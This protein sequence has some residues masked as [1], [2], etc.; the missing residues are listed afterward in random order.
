MYISA[1]DLREP[2]LEQDLLAGLRRV[3]PPARPI[4]LL[5]EGSAPRWRYGERLSDVIEESCLRHADRT[6]V[7]VET[8]DISY[9]ELDERANQMA[10]FLMARGVRPGDRVA[11][12]LDRGIETYVA[13]F[14]LLKAG[15][16]YVPLDANHPPDRIRFICS[17]AGANLAV[18]HLRLA[19]RL[20]GCRAPTLVLDG[21]RD[22]IASCDRTRLAE[23]ERGPAGDTLSYVLYTSGTT[24]QPKGVA[25]A[26]RSICN[27]VRVAA[28]RYG[29]GFGDRVY[30]GMSAAF[31]FSI[32]EVWV[33]LAAGA[34][35]VPNTGATSL[36]G[37]EL[38]DF[39]ESRKVTC[40]C[41]VPTLLASIEREL[42]RLRILLIG[43]EACPSAL[44]KRWGRAGRTLLN[45]YGPT[46]AT[47]TATLG[48]MTPDK[49][50]TIGKP[51]PTY[52]IVILDPKEDV[53]LSIGEAGE[54]GIAGV[55]VA[56]G[57]LNRLDLTQA[58]FIED[59]LVLPNN[60]SGRIYRTGDLG[61]I[62]ESGEVEYLGRIDK[63]I[64]LR[65]YR[66]ELTEIESVL[67]EIPEIS[68]VVA[69]TFE[70]APGQAE[71]VAYYSVKHGANAPNRA[72]IVSHMR[73]KLPSYMTPAYLEQL[74][75]IPTQVSNKADRKGLPAPKSAR[76]LLGQTHV[77]PET[78]TESALCRALAEVLGLEEVS[79]DGDFFADYSAH[80]LLMARFCARIR[81]LE[82]SLQVAM[83]DVYAHGTVRRLARALDEARPSPTENLEVP[84]AH[85]PS[86]LAY[87]GCAAAQLAFYAVVGALA[88]AAA[89]AAFVWIYDAADSPLALYGRALGVAT[90][91]FLGHNALAVAAKWALI[92]RARRGSV[93]IWSFAY[94]RF[95]AAKLVV[96]S[97][98]AN[99]FAGTA[100]FNVFLRLLG[101]R[102]GRNALIASRFVPVTADLF[103]VGEDAVVMRSALLPGYCA[104]GNRIHTGA[105]RIGRN[106]YVGEH[107]V[108]EIQTAIGDCGQL[109][110]ASSLQSG[111]RV[112]DGQ[113]H[114]GSP[115]EE[116]TTS[117][118]LADEVSVSP[119]RR[120]LFNAMRLVFV[121]AVAGAL[122]DAVI[123]YAMAV[124]S[125]GDDALAL[126]PLDAAVVVAPMAASA[127]LAVA[128]VAL[129]G[130]LLIVYAVPR[131]AN[132]FLVEGQVYP[133]YGFHHGMQQIVDTF[134]N[135]RFFNLMFGDSVLI[136][137]YLRWVGW[138]LGLGDRTGS[139]FG[140]EQGQDNPFLC[141]VGANTV[142]SDALWLGNVTMSSRAYRLGACRIGARNFLGTMV[143][144]PPGARTGDNV[145]LATKVMAP[146]DGP[147]RENVG[148]L[149][150]P[151]FEIPRAASRDLDVL[152]A[153]GPEERARR[154]VRKTWLNMA[155][156]AGLLASRW[157]ILFIGIYVFGWTVAVY[158]VNDPLP[159]IVS[160]AVIVALSTAV[161]IVIERASLGF[162]RLKPE[163]ATVYDPAFWRIERHWKLSDTPLA[164]AFA[165]T[166]MRNVISRLL[167][168]KVGRRVF[169][170]GCILS[171]R[172]LVEI[173]DEANLNEHGLI[174][175]H[176]LEEGVFKSDLVRIGADC[177]VG[178]GSLVHYGVTMNEN[179]H[180]D[181]DAFLMKG[182]ITPAG[183]RWRGNPA[184]L[185]HAG[186]SNAG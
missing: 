94:F 29:F 113:R 28:E 152:A 7:S 166:P 15:A 160:A 161:F 83:R 73:A 128:V 183:S 107:S 21:M 46:E 132:A 42:P 135:S 108:L 17:D 41:C 158:G 40:L 186:A 81:Q 167:G 24:G 172:S 34:T 68:Q 33:P 74:P 140:S 139:N 47:V 92:G 91:W 157:F 168:V 45:S 178:V 134:G 62:A 90:A 121:I 95:W 97:A 70:P 54:I 22:E 111:Q 150:S 85:R 180:L 78:E 171:E 130:G 165:G 133:L 93:P 67:L 182:E 38:A 149:G 170:D 1:L 105:I 103:E 155:S 127:A 142:A 181:A 154:L 50:V 76:L 162:G 51:L 126:S 148:L 89:Q 120:W 102:I 53:A 169:D 143:Y 26:H 88:V 137:S 145:L 125:G 138:K 79:I 4:A 48:V 99:A 116:T 177:S 96:R 110:H 151:P 156:I 141:S 173:G 39:L 10:R 32:E 101:A 5:S 106:A 56:E 185:V 37:E 117:F 115:A 184:K 112:P 84:P 131:L 72:A 163:I 59:F 9:R 144:V 25:V 77:P 159:M 87:Y 16:A 3:E 82:P 49:P 136:E 36:F 19:E 13:L 164:T 6:A 153:V 71:L 98:P 58:R 14:A 65:G 43:G 60:S 55:G 175:A 179:T 63:Q 129:I 31:D 30:Q 52:S 114:A 64:K 146:I 12:L 57:Y 86:S 122:T 100:L 8:A 11:V 119:L 118:R 123:V 66:I 124:L 174:Q 147:V 176:S 35:L 2:Q 44:V 20:D 69:T 109:G 23:G 18:T 75:F 104:A 61:R 80:S 27:F